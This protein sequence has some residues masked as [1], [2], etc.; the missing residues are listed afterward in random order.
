MRIG[1]TGQ[2]GFI[3]THLYNYLGLYNSIERVSFNDEYFDDKEKLYKF[4][5]ACDVIIHLAALNRHEE[6]KVIYETNLKLVKQ[7]I[8]AMEYLEVRPHVFFS[9][10][11]HEEQNTEYGRSKKEGRLLFEA[12]SERTGAPFTGLV[13]PNIFGPFGRP[14]YN[15]FVATFCHK[16]THGESPE[17]IHDSNVNLIYVG[18]LCSFIT[19]KIL[20]KEKSSGKNCIKINVPSDFECN[21]SDILSKLNYYKE[22]YFDKGYFPDLK[23]IN[24]INLFNTFRSFIDYKNYFPF[25]LAKNSDVR[26]VFV[27]VMKISNG[28][29]VS[30]ST[31]VPGVTRGNHYHTRKIERFVV[32]KGKALIQMRK[33]GSSEILEFT[34]SGDEPSY[35]DMPVWYS[36]NI[37][38][39]GNDDLYTLFWINEWYNPND[40]DTFFEEVKFNEKA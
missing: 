4:I 16:L 15:S 10:S 29:Q 38:N 2:T 18:S 22:H 40:G 24:D 3:G 5:E 13:I 28:G 25:R 39:I 37:S 17:I 14:N 20:D 21:V 6:Q 32:L 23:S 31:T 1:I 12:W 19:N 11:I 7:L 27:E 9:S 30:F 26:G 36:H 33:I 35:V 34:L 8:S